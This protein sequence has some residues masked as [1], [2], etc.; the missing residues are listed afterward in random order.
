MYQMDLQ[1]VTLARLCDDAAGELWFASLYRVPED[2][3]GQATF[4]A[5]ADG[6]LAGLAVADLVGCLACHK[7]FVFFLSQAWL[8]HVVCS[9]SSSI[10]PAMIAA[11]KWDI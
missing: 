10:A 1:T 9:A 4:L 6:V 5:K 11:A 8:Q 7:C 2:L 3:E